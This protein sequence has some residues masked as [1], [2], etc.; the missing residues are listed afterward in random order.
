MAARAAVF[1]AILVSSFSTPAHCPPPGGEGGSPPGEV[2]GPVRSALEEAA[3]AAAAAPEGS[4]KR[5]RLLHRSGDPE[6]AWEIVTMMPP[7]PLELETLRAEIALTLYDLSEAHV[8]IERLRK[9]APDSERTRRLIVGWCLITD[10]LEG[11]E[12][13]CTQALERRPSSPA[14]ALGKGRLCRGLIRQPKARYWFRRALSHAGDD[15]ERARALEGIADIHYDLQSYDSSLVYLQRALPLSAADDRL[16]ES[17]NLT[18]IRTGRVS[19]AIDA[20]ELAVEL[21]PFNEASQYQLGNG[22][23]RLSYTE[24]EAAHP[25]AFPDSAQAAALARADSLAAAGAKDEALELLARIA[26][27]HPR[28]TDVHTRLGSLRF[29]MQEYDAALK[30]F[31]DAVRACPGNGR[32]RNGIAKALEA[33]RMAFDVHR[34]DYEEAFAADTAAEVP[35]I[36]EL[37]VNYDALSDRHKKRVAM[38]IDPLRRFVPVLVESGST[39]YI[40]PLYQ[41]LSS[42]PGLEALKDARIDYD[43][44]LW[45]D[46]RG[47]GGYATVTGVEDVERSVLGGYNTVLHELSHQV[48]GVLTVEENRV[49]QDLYSK[50]KGRD[51]RG[52]EAFVS[53]YQGSSVWEYL[54]EGINACM[55]PRRDGYDSKHVVRERLETR[56]PDLLAFVEQLM[57]VENMESY[58]AVGFANAGA[59]RLSRNLVGESIALFEKSIERDPR[60]PEGVRGLM[61]ALSIL[62]RHEEACEVAER[63]LSDHPDKAQVVVSAARAH[64]VRDG[65]NGA[66]LDRLLEMRSAVESRER[67]LIDLELGDAYFT[68]GELGPAIEAF[69]GVLDYQADNPEAL[70]GMG[71]A[72]AVAGDVDS[73]RD[74]FDRALLRR[75][76][77]VNLRTDYA[78]ALLLAGDFEGARAQLAEASLLDRASYRVAAV[79]GRLEIARGLPEEAL[80]P[81]Q[82][83]L[84]AAPHYDLARTLLA[85]AKLE[86]GHP[87]DAWSELAPALERSE[88][89]DPPEYVYNKTTAAFELAHTVPGDE[90]RL[91]Y[92]TASKAAAALGRDSDA[93][94]FARLAAEALRLPR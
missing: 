16:L 32:G 91:L 30:H 65:D 41:R 53:R 71:F 42:C 26:A 57:A 13:F 60:S 89:R 37:V 8:S 38:S 73:A 49:I 19:E 72:A 6:A 55:T 25:E 9:S 1:L 69:A 17:L 18:L 77:L 54:A 51:S 75:S 48:H 64:Y 82:A 31:R 10:D 63:A 88:R 62:G 76:G 78:T 52:V 59:D 74:Y 7:G 3:L 40:K 92:D 36:E 14:A 43:S 29:E 66:R 94:R 5:A 4:L 67:Y 80:R 87:E 83:S 46:V 11:L 47:C 93:R 61:Q 90:R 79:K 44:R 12:I 45:D 28:L 24:L 23:T 86:L 68:A 15:R 21:N 70:W 27:A 2:L 20:A 22:Y 84:D 33:K 85:R 58:Y 56:D 34:K 39:F 50:A 35:H 81:L